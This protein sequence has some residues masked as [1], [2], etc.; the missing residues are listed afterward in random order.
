MFAE[1]KDEHEFEL[2]KELLTQDVYR[3]DEED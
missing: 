1:H 2:Q 3:R